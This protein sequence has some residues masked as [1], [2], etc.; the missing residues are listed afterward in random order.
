MS[1]R[2][3]T[4]EK[5]GPVQIGAAAR[6]AKGIAMLLGGARHAEIATAC[7]VSVR[8]VERWAA[9][10]DVRAQ[11]ATATAE[12][13][14][15]ARGVLEAAAREAAESLVTIM[16]DS[17]ATAADRLRATLAVL[18]RTGHEAGTKVEHRVLAALPSSD[19]EAHARF[20]ALSRLAR[21]ESGRR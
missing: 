6:R 13:I 8:Q 1:E 10:P 5:G 9:L 20:A 14:A 11:A 3:E 21:S 16:R 15:T 18:D 12:A 17:S 4:A 19:D 2:R 7:G